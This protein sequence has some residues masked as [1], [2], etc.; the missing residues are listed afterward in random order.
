MAAGGGASPLPA[1]GGGPQ[2]QAPSPAPIMNLT[3][4]TTRPYEPINSRLGSSKYRNA[5]VEGVL[6]LMYDLVPDEALGRLINDR[7]M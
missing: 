1:T 2:P 6:K 3:G 4:P 5:E 7:S